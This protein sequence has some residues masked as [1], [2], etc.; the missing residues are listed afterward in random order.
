MAADAHE[1]AAFESAAK[2]LP[3]LDEL[4]T[5][6][7][8]HDPK[9]KDFDRIVA[10]YKLLGKVFPGMLDPERM[11]DSRNL[12]FDP[13]RFK[14]NNLLG[15]GGE[16]K[17]YH[18][19]A[20]DSAEPSWILKYYRKRKGSVDELVEQGKEIREEYERI[21]KWYSIIPGIVPEEHMMIA[22]D[23]KSQEA[24]LVI[25]REFVADEILD[26]FADISEQKLIKLLESNHK[27]RDDFQKFCQ[28]TFFHEEET[29]EVIDL[30]GNKN[31]SLLR[32]GNEYKLVI[33]DPHIIYSTEKSIEHKKVR[34]K[35]CLNNYELIADDSSENEALINEPL[36]L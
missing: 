5:T 27:L 21:K 25:V 33:L 34:L 30:L 18:L 8:S 3:A 28:I 9:V 1:Y 11:Y 2:P 36:Q 22:E 23:P 15:M 31:V 14:F 6:M 20:K 26:I 17:V 10:F 35:R 7:E 16:S 4:M 19:E 12:P 24:M 29:H 13:K 32:R